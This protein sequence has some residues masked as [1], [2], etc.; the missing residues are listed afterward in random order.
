MGRKET[1]AKYKETERLFSESRL[2]QVFRSIQ[3]YTWSG[4][5]L[6]ATSAV[7]LLIFSPSCTLARMKILA[8]GCDLR[9]FNLNSYVDL[10]I[11]LGAI[12]LVLIVFG[13]HILM[14]VFILWFALNPNAL[15]S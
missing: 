11:G 1:H 14:N 10:F 7:A 13:L 2:G 3:F 5:L 9:G 15:N 6:F 4:Y 8:S 12:P